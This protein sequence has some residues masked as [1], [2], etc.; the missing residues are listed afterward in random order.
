MARKFVIDT[1]VFL[2]PDSIKGFAKNPKQA[3]EKFIDL[4]KKNREVEVYIPSAIYNE[5]GHFLDNV[6]AMSPYV[7]IR[8][9]NLYSVYI[10]AA[11]MH[12]LINNVRDRINKG[13][14]IA[15]EYARLNYVKPEDIAKLR[16]KYREALRTGIIDSKEDF[17]AIILAKEIDATLVTADEGMINMAR[18]IGCEYMEP[19][20]FFRFIKE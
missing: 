13:L 6:N 11:V 19:K 14:R 18:E 16:E 5:L 15:E 20:A 8:T 10:P 9:P 7:R 1:S 4:I 3:L 17:E 12:S 2:N